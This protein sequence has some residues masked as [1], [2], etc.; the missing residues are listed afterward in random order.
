MNTSQTNEM[1]SLNQVREMKTTEIICSKKAESGFIGGLDALRNTSCCNPT[2]ASSSCLFDDSNVS[3]LTRVGIMYYQTKDFLTAQKY[4]FMALDKVDN[5]NNDTKRHHHYGGGCSSSSSSASLL[6]ENKSCSSF[7]FTTTSSSTTCSQECDEGVHCFDDVIMFEDNENIEDMRAIIQFNIGQTNLA[8]RN[9]KEAMDWFNQTTE[10]YQS[11]LFM[12]KSVHNI[13]YCYFSM[14]NFEAALKYFHQASQML[15]NLHLSTTMMATVTYSSLGV[16]LFNTNI[17]DT[18][19]S[20]LLFQKC[21]QIY[22]SNTGTYNNTKQEGTLWNNFGRV[23]YLEGDFEKATECYERSLILR[24]KEF[25]IDSIDVAATYYNLGNVNQKVQKLEQAIECYQEFLR[26]AE[27]KLGFKS[28]EVVV[29][30]KCIGE[31][32][33]KLKQPESAL[34]QYEKA[35]ELARRALMDD[36]REISAILNKAGNIC[37]EIGKYDKALKYYT[38]GL[39]IENA[40]RTNYDKNSVIVTLTNIAQTYKQMGRMDMA[41]DFYRQVYSIQI[42]DSESKKLDIASTLS[43]IGLMLYHTE[44]YEKAFE[45][46]QEALQLRRDHHGSDDNIDIATTLNSIGLV[47]FKQGLFELCNEC[48]SRCLQIRL[49]LFGPC[50]KDVAMVWYNLASVSFE[51]G[52]DETAIERYEEALRIEKA[53]LGDDHQNIILTLVH[54][55]Q[56]KQQCGLLED[57]IKVLSDALQIQQKQTKSDTAREARIYNLLGNCF[58]QRGDVS[59]MMDAY[60]SASRLLMIINRSNEPLTIKGYNIYGLSKLH[61]ECAPVA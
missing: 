42:N 43:S 36:E 12:Y 6:L 1:F 56:V 59:K 24:R 61:P 5:H 14:K 48:F 23:Y 46:Y 55:G 21:L 22:T 28:K 15:C 19:P 9:Y 44:Y 52:D 31:I 8:R 40:Y 33:Q 35:W 3:S 39:Q 11:T 32:L 10:H 13:G 25:G 2:T 51:I 47:L 38:S 54:L 53:S 57:A 60:T 30:Y 7:D 50:H 16:V 26:I 49:K 41:L 29:V 18:K 27:L 17:S 20:L 34:Q 58:L 4:F 37:F 45:T